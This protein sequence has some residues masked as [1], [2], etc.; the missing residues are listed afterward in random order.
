[1]VDGLSATT[2]FGTEGLVVDV[3]SGYWYETTNKPERT[4]PLLDTATE[5]HFITTPTG[6]N[7]STST[8]YFVQS[9]FKIL[10][11]SNTNTLGKINAR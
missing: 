1:M 3:V 7:M 11:Y 6:L 9:Q 2:M 8:S 10:L 4:L 5:T